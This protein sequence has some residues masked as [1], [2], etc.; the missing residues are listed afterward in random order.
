MVRRE[1]AAE[2]DRLDGER[3]LQ[4]LAED[5]SRLLRLARRLAPDGVEPEDLVQDAFERA[6]RSRESFRGSAAPRTWLYAILVNRARDLIRSPS[7]AVEPFDDELALLDVLVDDPAAVVARAEAEDE[8]R[9]ALATLPP[10]ERTAVALHD[11]EGWTAAEVARVSACSLD[12]AHKRIQRGRYR[13]ADALAGRA[14]GARPPRAPH[15]CRSA[16]LAASAFLD[17]DLAG[18]DAVEVEEH[19]R[20]CDYCP[21]V[22]QSLVGI[23]AALL[24]ARTDVPRSLLKRLERTLDASLEDP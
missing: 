15:T 14:D 22:V 8:L 16:R 1:S 5:A 18:E 24:E 17:G 13:L 3:L 23:R 2:L 6:W 20:G 11:G 19:L 9:A 7:P 21:P 12:A 10:E 4:E